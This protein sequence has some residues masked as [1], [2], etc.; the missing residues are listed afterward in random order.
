MFL[1]RL[2]LSHPVD[3]VDMELTS[4]YDHDDLHN[5]LVYPNPVNDLLNFESVLFNE[6]VVVTLFNM[7]GHEVVAP[8]DFVQSKLVVDVSKLVSGMYVVKVE[9]EGEDAI[10]FR[11]VKN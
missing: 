2:H 1:L 4:V 7:L 5:V 3:C 6:N 10:V 8:V 11:V 9:I